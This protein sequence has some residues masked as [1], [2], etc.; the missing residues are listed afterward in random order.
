[1][2]KILMR[3][4]FAGLV[5]GLVWMMS[6]GWPA[7]ARA[8]SAVWTGQGGDNTWTNTGNW[9]PAVIPN[10]ANDTATFTNNNPVWTNL[11]LGPASITLSNFVLAAGAPAFTFSASGGVYLLLSANGDITVSAGVTNI[12]DLS[13]VP[14]IRGASG[15]STAFNVA[16]NGTALLKLPVLTQYTGSGNIRVV[17]SGAAGAPISATVNDR[18]AQTT[19]ALL[20]APVVLYLQDTGNNGNFNGG[21]FLRA[22]TVSAASVALNSV[23]H[24]PLGTGNFV[25]VGSDDNTG[26]SSTVQFTGPGAGTTDE[27]FALTKGNTGVF[28]IT[29]SGGNL[30][31]TSSLNESNSSSTTLPGNLVKTG[32]GTLTLNAKGGF[33]GSTT[34]ANGTLSLGVANA[35][36]TSGNVMLGGAGMAGVLDLGGFSQQLG[37]LAVANAAVAGSQVISN[38]ST[39]SPATLV[40]SNAPANPSVFGG[41][42]VDGARP[43]ALTVLNGSLTLTNASTYSGITTITAG[44]LALGAGGSLANIAAILI[45]TNATFNVSGGGFTLATGQTLAGYGVITG[46]VSAVGGLISPGTNGVAGT[47]T[48]ANGLTLAGGVTNHFDL[49]LTPN[50]AGNDLILVGGALKVS[51]TNTIEIN[52][53][54]TTLSV[55]TY[56]LIKFGSLADGGAANFQVTGNL[57]ASLQGAVNV[58]AAEVDLVVSQ[59]GG[60]AR[61]WVGDGV[62]NAWDD[63]TPDWLYGGSPAVY[64]DGD[65]VT[66]DD[67]GS[68]TP[69]VNLTTLLRPAA[70]VV[71]AVADYTFTGAGAISGPATLTKTNAGTLTIL[72]ANNYSGLTTIAQGTLQLGD[73]T[74]AGSLGTNAIQNSGTLVFDLPGS[75]SIAN[76]ISG[77]GNLVQAGSGTLTLTAGNTYAG[78]TTI[79]AGTL[80]INTGAAFGSGGVTNNGA[81]V[82]NSTAAANVSAVISGTGSLTL[83]N[84]GTVALTGNNLYGGGTTVGKGTLL[85][86]NTAGSGTGSGAVIVAGGATLGGGGVIGGPVTITSGGIYSPGNPV[87]TLN[88]AGDFTAVSG[89]TLDFTLGTVSDRTGVGGNLDLSGTLN[90]TAGTGFTSGTYT[91]FTYNGALILGPLTLDLPANT[92][93]TLD[94]NTPGQVNLIVGTLQSNIPAF[95]GAYGFGAN[96][97]G[98]RFGGTVYHVT[99][100]NDSGAGSFRDAVSQ[101]GRFV[102]FD[103]G[104]YISLAG[105]VS[106]ANNLT[107]AGQ[108]APGGGIGIMGHEVSFSVKT[109]D[110]VRCV[111]FRPGSIASD[112]EDGINMGDATNMIFDHVSVEFAPY[113][114]ID[115]HGNDTCG[116]Q[117]TIQNSILADPIYQQFNAHT[118]A[119]NNTFSWLYNIFSSGHDRNP[120]AK[121]NTIF[122]NNVVNNFQGGYTVAGTGGNFSHDIINNCFITGPATTSAGDDFFQFDSNQSV[123]AAGNLLDSAD[124]GTLGGSATA[125]G[126]VTVLAAPWSALT[127]GIPTVSTVSA[128]RR[129]V[130]L[131]G[132]WPPD[133]VDQNVIGDVTSLG[134]A[135][136]GGGLW[137][138]QTATGLGNNGYGVITNGVAPADT[139]G[140]GVPD[141]FEAA[142]GSNPA[143]ADSLTPG[144][145][146]YTKLE[147]YLNWLA[148]PHV[149]TAVNTVVTV[150]LSP[151][152]AGFAG[153]GPVYSVSAA[154][155]GVVA[156]R[157]G[158]LAQFTPAVNFAGLGGFNFAVQGGDGSAMTNAVGVCVS[159]LLASA[160]PLGHPQFQQF[161]AGT[162]GL[163]MSGAGGPAG[164]YYFLL[165]ATNLL[166]PPGQWTLLATNQFDGNGG[167]GFTNPVPANSPLMFYLLQLP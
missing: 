102:V 125:P 66:F 76:L 122:I 115:A 31:L 54:G 41:V 152:A 43:V 36:S 70:V 86:N 155:N 80:Q 143:V 141:Y 106:C 95:P 23:G 48:F 101:S 121:V 67:T 111:R 57:G 158:H 151:Y 132:A 145:G 33:T 128:Y 3:R 127:P 42:I 28:D 16:N 68:R 94:T 126:G 69:P 167:F 130:S 40:F 107:I 119:S 13:G 131:S 163:V 150:D 50:P 1:M 161:N 90:L 165:G 91:L 133:Q 164:G 64:S 108:T 74:A 114:N 51:G 47:L 79:S 159:P 120:L 87:G 73:G 71:N 105:T 96:A 112:T 55:G 9:S 162:G 77:P 118:E 88:I 139:D 160:A 56:S 21:L 60:T 45:N 129:D 97:T 19:E 58:T 62:L 137:T 27:H 24:S 14:L 144:T 46:G 157:N 25:F 49:A 6:A 15:T 123:Y 134:T 117:I 38:G 52:P 65:F 35:I 34:I 2:I 83:A 99:N 7:P 26:Q 59:V 147:N 113:N 148:A 72:T 109:N 81:L 39:S 32:Q 29:N 140:D 17:F 18:G 100:T 11:N 82:I 61:T 146:G 104:G 63:T 10:G 153:V 156:L 85:V 135:G 4:P 103:I 8:T 110:I 93:A 92:T 44:T 37:A 124:N 53:L 5:A 20:N 166:L 98:A 30:I 149:A 138:T 136:M 154:A 75:A 89:A 84:T 142:V 12:E 78:G 22:G 116:N